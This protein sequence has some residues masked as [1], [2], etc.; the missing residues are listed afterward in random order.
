[1]DR[2]KGR[3][4]AV[5]LTGP[6]RW[7]RYTG[8]NEGNRETVFFEFDLPPGQREVPKDVY[9]VIKSVQYL[10]RSPEDG[11]GRYN[12]GLECRRGIGNSPRRTPD[13][14]PPIFWVHASAN[15]LKRLT[16]PSQRPLTQFTRRL[17][18]DCIFGSLGLLPWEQTSARW[19]SSDV[20][21]FAA[22]L[23]TR[24]GLI[25]STVMASLVSSMVTA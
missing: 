22:E 8:L 3:E 18:Y 12:T 23:S 17:S 21:C 7:R 20:P 9:D 24:N 11:G 15:L 16:P 2:S 10:E 25:W 4:W 6:L 1:M 13:V 14:P 5:K 19:Q